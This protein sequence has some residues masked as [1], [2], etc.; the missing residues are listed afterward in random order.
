VRGLRRREHLAWAFPLGLL[1]LT[2][3]RVCCVPAQLPDGAGSVEVRARVT[4]EVRAAEPRFRREALSRFPGDPWSQGDQ[5][6]AQE[7]DLVHRLAKREHMRPGAVFDAID[8]D[9]KSHA[10]DGPLLRD[11]GRVAPCMPRAFYD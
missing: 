10:Y 5:F 2:F 4:D 6:G 1:G 9:I 7:R 11:R 8:R 3:A